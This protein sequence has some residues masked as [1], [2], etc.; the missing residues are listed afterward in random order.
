MAFDASLN[1]VVLFGGQTATATSDE[2]WAWDGAA[3]EQLAI[4][5]AGTR[6][7][8][9]MAYDAEQQITVLHGGHATL[10]DFNDREYLGDTWVLTESGWATLTTEGPPARTYHAMDFDQG[11]QQLVFFGGLGSFSDSWTL[12]GDEWERLSTSNPAGR[13]GHTLSF[14]Q[15][16]DQL[17][18]FGGFTA[19]GFEHEATWIWKDQQWAAPA[20]SAPDSRQTGSLV[21]DPAQEELVFLGS[22]ASAEIWSFDGERWDGRIP[23]GPS[24]LSYSAYDTQSQRIVTVSRGLQPIDGSTRGD[25]W[26]LDGDSWSLQVADPPLQGSI[27]SVVFDDR[28]HTFLVITNTGISEDDSLEMSTWKWVANGWQLVAT[29][30]QT[31]PVF[32]HATAFDPVRGETILFGG[33]RFASGGV[34]V[35]SN[36][37]WTFDGESWRDIS[38][39]GPPALTWHSAAFDQARED[40]VLFGGL[41]TAGITG[42]TWTFDDSG[43]QKHAQAGPTPRYRHAM[44]YDPSTEEVILFGGLTSFD[45]FADLFS[46]ETWAWNGSAWSLRATTGPTPRE[47]SAMAFDPIHNELLIFG[48]AATIFPSG[49]QHDTWAWDG[50][51][52]QLRTENGPTLLKRPQM[53]FDPSLNQIVMVGTS[54]DASVTGTWA[55]NGSAW[56]PL[57][58][59]G[60]QP[61]TGHAMATDSARHQVVLFGG[62]TGAGI[63]ADTWALS[64]VC[65]ADFNADGI[66]DQGDILTFIT[67]FL[68]GC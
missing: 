2:T 34:R 59:A 49:L 11:S 44:A 56:S 57:A 15:H 5:D 54:P 37:T 66:V 16:R 52:W 61:R 33:Q 12:N 13:W 67:A 40:V 39:G 6:A 35:N 22:S 68:A 46:N 1:R 8:H 7:G 45:L 9:A 27:Q 26:I 14:D 24:D 65:T 31:P 51:A 43:W 19:G 60:P 50:S 48:G 55:W 42:E 28:L 63:A 47:G 3:W 58:T 4:T 20:G 53:A 41:D 25:L 64:Q 62:Q 18:L 17:V 23:Q 30:E 21:Y 36:E 10:T 32:R 29:A 38:G